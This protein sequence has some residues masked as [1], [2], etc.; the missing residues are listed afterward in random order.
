MTGKAIFAITLFII[1]YLILLTFAIGITILCLLG[2]IAMIVT[3]PILIIIGLGLGL[4]SLGIFIL[5]FLFKFLFKKHKVDRNHLYEIYEK[6]E[7]QLFSFIREIVNEVQT[8]FPKRVYLSNEV[9]ASV[10]YDSSFWS[11]IFPIRKNLQIGLGLVNT[12]SEQEFKAILAH[13][14]GHFSQRSMK[15]GSYVY[16]VNQIIFN[17]LYDNESYDYLI[18]RWANTSRFFSFFVSIAVKIIEGIQWVLRKM[19]EYVNV[20]YLALSREMEFHADEIAANVAGYLPLKESL[21]RME[22]AEH[23]YNLVLD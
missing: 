18:Q 20:S 6:D 16:N 3:K 15:V 1:T 21:R 11:M 5:I 10:F 4:A 17:M 23:S 14:F 9:N 19:Y 7:P 8:D 2:G 22:L 12:I 13:E